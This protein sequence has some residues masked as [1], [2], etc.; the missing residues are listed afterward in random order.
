LALN[1]KLRRYNLGSGHNVTEAS[2][3]MADGSLITIRG[4]V[5]YSD[6]FRDKGQSSTAAIMVGRCDLALSNPR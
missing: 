6:R 2:D 5:L 4:G 1:F 3:G